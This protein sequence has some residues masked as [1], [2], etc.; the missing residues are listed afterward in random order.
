MTISDWVE[1][2][3]SYTEC[4]I[5]G[6]VPLT[7]LYVAEGGFLEVQEEGGFYGSAMVIATPSYTK[8]GLIGSSLQWEGLSKANLL[9]ST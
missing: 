6:M 3:C 9:L 7:G 4:Q 2:A 8:C 5:L 1:T